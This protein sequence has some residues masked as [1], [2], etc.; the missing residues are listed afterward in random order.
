MSSLISKFSSQEWLWERV[1]RCSGWWQDGV[2]TTKTN[3]SKKKKAL[4]ILTDAWLLVSIHNIPGFYFNRYGYSGFVRPWQHEVMIP[5]HHLISRLW[6]SLFESK[7]ARLT[8]TLQGT[9]GICLWAR[10][11]RLLAGVESDRYETIVGHQKYVL[12]K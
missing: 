5:F 11:L 8:V 1:G 12:G 4:R 9:L 10:V 3:D 6:C 7:L 2:K